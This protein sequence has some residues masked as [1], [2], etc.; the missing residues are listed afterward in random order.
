VTPLAIVATRV[1]DLGPAPRDLVEIAVLRVDPSDTHATDVFVGVVRSPRGIRPHDVGA[2]WLADVVDRVRHL[3]RGCRLAAWNGAETREYLEALCDQWELLPL[4]LAEGVLDLRSLAAPLVATREARGECL[5]DAAIAV[6][7][8]H[9]P[10]ALDE[11]KVLAEIHRAITRRFEFTAPMKGLDDDEHAILRL[12]LD[13]IAGGRKQ[14]GPWRVDDGRN[15]PR[16]ALEEAVDG[17]AYLAAEIVRL[18]KRGVA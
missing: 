11:V 17:M 4:E 18:R 3:T 13:R 5:I 2:M 14:Y 1:D 12:L 7:A 8:T 9:G 10:G 6:G 16:E 15:Y